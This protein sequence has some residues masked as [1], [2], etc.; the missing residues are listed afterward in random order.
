MLEIKECVRCR[1][2]LP[3][4]EF[5]PNRR[6]VDGLQVYC[7]DCEIEMEIKVSK[8]REAK[9]TAYKGNWKGS[10][11]AIDVQT[12]EVIG[13]YRTTREAEA[14]LYVSRQAIS[15]S[16]NNKRK[17]NIAC[18]KYIFKYEDDLYKSKGILGI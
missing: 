11:A 3:V 5:E 4:S 16:L 18:G 15:D 1:R 13:I 6:T 17:T 14:N 2:T 8:K 9:K 12:G 7:K 10:I